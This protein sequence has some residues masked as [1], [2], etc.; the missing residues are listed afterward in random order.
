MKR[1][2][3]GS[4]CFGHCWVAG[5]APLFLPHTT[6]TNAPTMHYIC[7]QKC[8]AFAPKMCYICTQ[9]CDAFA[10]TM[11]YIC[12]H[13]MWRICTKNVLHLHQKCDTFAQGMWHV[14]TNNAPYLYQHYD[15]F[16]PIPQYIGSKTMIYLHKKGNI[17]AIYISLY[18]SCASVS[19]SLCCERQSW[20]C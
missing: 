14:F 10:P 17:F 3:I 5:G 9:K 13:K 7:T 6:P 11:H 15:V 20:V 18:Y 8:D 2:K 19:I 4:G 12:T 1:L 16:A